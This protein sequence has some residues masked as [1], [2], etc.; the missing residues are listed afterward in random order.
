MKVLGYVDSNYAKIQLSKVFSEMDQYFEWFNGVDGFFIDQGMA[1]M[2]S[3][4]CALT[5]TQQ[6]PSALT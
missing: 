3:A 6:A 2:C 5:I 4:L 1:S